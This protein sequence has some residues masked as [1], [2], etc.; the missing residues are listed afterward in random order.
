MQ[1]KEKDDENF[2]LMSSRVK[3]YETDIDR[4]CRSGSR[5]K[6]A[7]V[8]RLVD[9]QAESLRQTE[10]AEKL[11]QEQAA[12]IAAELADNIAALSKTVAGTTA[13]EKLLEL[14]VVRVSG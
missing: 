14:K 3:Q 5:F 7:Q 9:A 12:K 10:A 8:T 6:I 4:R 13:V 11:A 2:R 1:L